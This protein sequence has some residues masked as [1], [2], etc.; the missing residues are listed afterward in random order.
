[1]NEWQEQSSAAGAGIRPAVILSG[2]KYLM[3]K[4]KSTKKE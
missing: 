4:K 3:N 2:V 1:M